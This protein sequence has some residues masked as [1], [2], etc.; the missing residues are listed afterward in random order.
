LAFTPR[1]LMPSGVTL[2]VSNG[3]RYVRVTEG[4][5]V[6]QRLFKTSVGAERY[7]AAIEIARNLRK[8]SDASE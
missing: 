1:T 6:T 3:I 5:K 2:T 4:K 7:I 8:P